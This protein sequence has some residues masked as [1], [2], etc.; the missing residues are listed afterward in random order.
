[1]N[2]FYRDFFDYD[3][4]LIATPVYEMGITGQLAAY[5]SRFRPHYLKQKKDPNA[6]LFKPGAALAVG[7]TRNGGQEMTILVIHNFFHTSGMMIV[8]GGLGAYGGAAVWSQDKMAKGAE[9]DLKGME[10]ARTVGY[11]L[12]LAVAAISKGLEKA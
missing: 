10:N 8:N 6:M 12:G 11:R 9:E 1:M 7:G 5:F 3:G 2:Q 4:V